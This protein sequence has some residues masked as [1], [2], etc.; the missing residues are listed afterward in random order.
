MSRLGLAKL[1]LCLGIAGVYSAF[2]APA[3]AEPQ[4]FGGGRRVTVHTQPTLYISD[5][6]SGVVEIYA[7][8]GHDQRPIGSITGLGASLGLFVDERRHFYISQAGGAAVLEFAPGG[9]TPEKIYDDA[10]HLPQGVTRCPNGTLYVSNVDGDTIS[11][12]AHGSTEPT[13]T[14]VDSGVQVFSL[15]CD[16]ASDLFVTV[17]GK[18]YQV[19]EFIAGSSE[20][21]N[22]PI[23]LTFPEGI[24]I[25]RAGDIVVADGAGGS[26]EF[27]HVGDATPFY[28]IKVPNG[29]FQLSFD[30]DD[31]YLWVTTAND[32]ERYAVSSG[33]M[34]DAI[35]LT[36]GALAASPAD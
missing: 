3:N 26:V 24:Q 31:A 27:Y 36:A 12:Y 30:R 32:V 20:A 4:P 35:A 8:K 22:L 11:V 2:A 28:S 13:R 33:R 6:F 21:V 5:F 23:S 16:A 34:A 18:Q 25:D 1:V 9:T 19:D 29:S 15:A 17:G 10:G 14:L 7:Q